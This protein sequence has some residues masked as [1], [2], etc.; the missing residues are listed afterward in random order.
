MPEEHY[1]PT[2]EELI[3]QQTGDAYC[4]QAR[5]IHER[6]GSTLSIDKNGFHVRISSIDAGVKESVPH[7]ILKRMLDLKR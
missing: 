1:L 5:E 2:L 7:T 6:S 4:G 3:S